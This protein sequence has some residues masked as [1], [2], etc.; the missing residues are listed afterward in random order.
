MRQD[1]PLP[2]QIDG[3]AK[4]LPHIFTGKHDIGG[5]G[6]TE[7]GL[8]LEVVFFQQTRHLV[9]QQ[10]RRDAAL[11]EPRH[12]PRR[13]GGI[14]DGG[15]DAGLAVL[16]QQVADDG[17][18]VSDADPRGRVVLAEQRADDEQ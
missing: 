4:S 15:A 14:H 7:L 13:G 18:V 12:H 16:V 10:R 1:H 6:A 9:H 2:R 8:D 11:R 17:L 5:R 3:I